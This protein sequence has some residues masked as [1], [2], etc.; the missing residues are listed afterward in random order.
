MSPRALASCAC[1]A[2]LLAAATASF[3]AQDM[4][5]PFIWSDQT[6]KRDMPWMG[7]G[8]RARWFVIDKTKPWD[9][10]NPRGP[11]LERH[12]G[13]S[14]GSG[15]SPY[16]DA[17]RMMAYLDRVGFLKQWPRYP[18]DSG[19]NDAVALPYRITVVAIQPTVAI[20]RF[21]LASIVED[22]IEFSFGAFPASQRDN[23][24]D[25][26]LT[27]SNV[28]NRIMMGTRVAHNGSMMWFCPEENIA[29]RPLDVSSGHAEIALKNFKLGVDLK[30]E[31]YEVAW[32][33]R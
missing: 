11:T 32:R 31:E 17:D 15:T 26:E 3:G 1:V 18:A 13:S 7:K 23:A 28:P 22:P 10:M 14:G 29:P 5:L 27:W 2:T 6:G 19:H 20:L 30:G 33:A 12:W 24:T 16:E 8:G 25:Q 21:D 4:A 9:F